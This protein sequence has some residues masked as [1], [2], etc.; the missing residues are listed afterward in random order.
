MYYSSLQ[1]LPCHSAIAQAFAEGNLYILVH[2]QIIAE[3]ELS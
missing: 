3:A 2:Q 1:N